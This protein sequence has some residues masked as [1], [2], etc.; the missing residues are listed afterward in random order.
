[1]VV[2]TKL[3]INGKTFTDVDKL[4]VTSSIGDNNSVSHFKALIKNYAGEYASTF[5]IGNDVEIFH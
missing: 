2:Q 3:D 4:E 5:S 1:M